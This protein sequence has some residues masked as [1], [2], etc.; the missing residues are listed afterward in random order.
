M[1][2]DVYWQWGLG[3]GLPADDVTA[4]YSLTNRRA[5]G[6]MLIGGVALHDRRLV[7]D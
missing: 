1:N 3:D 4:M 5:Q 6:L 7:K 2:V